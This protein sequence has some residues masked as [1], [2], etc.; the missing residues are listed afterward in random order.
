MLKSILTTFFL[1]F[2]SFTHAQT[3]EET[4]A[5]LISK[6]KKSDVVRLH[7]VGDLYQS[8]NNYNTIEQ[9]EITIAKVVNCELK[10]Q[11]LEISFYEEIRP[12]ETV[13]V[14]YE[15]SYKIDLSKLDTLKMNNRD[16]RFLFTN[17]NHISQALKRKQYKL[18]R[19]YRGGPYMNQD[20]E[21]TEYNWSYIGYDDSCQLKIND[22]AEP[23]MYNRIVKAIKHYSRIMPIVNE[24]KEVF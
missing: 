17:G 21:Q 11:F 24:R 9:G 6:L 10:N 19:Q 18:Y 8:Y 20:T 3:I 12:L 22:N 14:V 15:Y 16:G 2:F 7:N 4:K 1:L 13:R 23:D 5:W